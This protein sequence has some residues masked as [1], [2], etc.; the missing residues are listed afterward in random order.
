MT[1]LRPGV[2][3]VGFGSAPSEDALRHALSSKDRIFVVMLSKEME[4][5][6]ARIV[7]GEK[8][9]ESPGQG[10]F[11]ILGA[12][13]RMQSQ[14]TSK[15]QRMLVYRVAEWYGIKAVSGPD[16]AI[17]IGVMGHLDPKR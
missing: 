15:F 12:N 10:H 4:A 1:V 17:Y 3:Q 6:I 8:P 7:A 16:L 5:F 13:V 11:S 2:A 14:P 9:A